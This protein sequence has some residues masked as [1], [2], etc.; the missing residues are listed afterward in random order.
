MSAG[1]WSVAFAPLVPLWALAALATAAIALLGAAL[2][3]GAR[4]V[5]LRAAAFAVGLLALANP[6]AVEEEREPVHEVAAVVVDVSRSQ[7][8]GERRARTEAAV[9]EIAAALRAHDDLDVRVIRVGNEEGTDGTRLFAALE[10]TLADVPP[11]RVAATVLV[12][13][14]QVHDAPDAAALDGADGRASLAGPVHALLTGARDEGDR[15]LVVVRAPSYGVVDGQVGVTVRVEDTAASDGI[16]ELRVVIDGGAVSRTVRAPIGR[17]LEL[18]V[19]LEHAG[20][21]VLELEV[22]P[23]THELTVGNNR[24]AVVVNGVRDRLRVMLVSGEP[25]AGERMWRNL[26]KADP[27]VD[28][29][30]FTILR[31]PEKQNATPIRELSLIAFPVRQ[32]F[33][34]QLTDFDLIIFDRYRQRGVIPTVYLRNVAEYVREGGAV[35]EAAGPEFATSLSLYATPVAAVLPGEPT[36]VTEA[37][38]RPKVSTLGRRHPVTAG[39]AGAA[40]EEPEWGRWFRIVDAVRRRGDILMEGEEGRPLLILDRVGDGR[41]AQ[42]LSDQAW[43]WTRGYEGGGPQAELLRRVAHWLMKEPELEEE[44]LV[45]TATDRRIEIARRTLAADP[46][47]EATVRAPDGTETTVVLEP[48]GGGRWTAALAAETP[49]LYRVE[50]GGMSALAAVGALNP[51]EQ[52]DLRTTAAALRPVAEATGGGVFWLTDGGVPEV[53]RV[54]AGRDAAGRG[55]M[56]VPATDSYAVVGVRETPLIP[57]FLALLA[58]L[59][60]LIGAWV[61]EG[62]STG[63]PTRTAR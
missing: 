49:G 61:R 13:D 57:A 7:D 60:S 27:S 3:R 52:A 33:E 25:H 50:A 54:R 62:D 37:P 30:H 39:L 48:A 16:A 20:P 44:A 51:L 55:W 53:R 59:G 10:R 5:G 8:V 6:A 35:L 2:L 34:E 19:L 56:G 14:G 26:L 17:D 42:L 46:A 28:L 32:L 43:L 29:V 15:R 58:L 9:A 31:P 18:P 12:T 21:T 11:E 4:G 63:R 45:A 47:R 36:G 22:A 38:F 1:A 23:G 41:V 24:A 40:A